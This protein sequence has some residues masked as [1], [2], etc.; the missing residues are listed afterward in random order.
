MARSPVATLLETQR[1]LHE[2]S[3]KGAKLVQLNFELFS[4]Y[5]SNGTIYYIFI[6]M[7]LYLKVINISKLRKFPRDQCRT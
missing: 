5:L 7:Y 3:R 4:I 6:H 1:L 2:L